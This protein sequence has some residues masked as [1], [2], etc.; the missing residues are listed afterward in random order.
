M[1]RLGKLTG[2]IYEENEIHNMKEC[3]ICITD[4]QS[5]NEKWIK[6]RRAKDLADC[7]NCRGCTFEK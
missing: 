1:K 5:N 7:A 2:K 3:G 6:Q 4:E